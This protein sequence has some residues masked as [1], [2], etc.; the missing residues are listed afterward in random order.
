MIPVEGQLSVKLIG[1]VAVRDLAF[2]SF[3]DL[4][5]GRPIDSE[6]RHSIL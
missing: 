6:A 1:C 4:S 3:L 2:D 5:V